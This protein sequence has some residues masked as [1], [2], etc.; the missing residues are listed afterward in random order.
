MDQVIVQRN[1]TV[2]EKKE[3]VVREGKGLVEEVSSVF[4]ASARQIKQERTESPDGS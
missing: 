4:A 2:K 3:I 1:V